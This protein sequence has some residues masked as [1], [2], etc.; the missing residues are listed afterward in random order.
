MRCGKVFGKVDG[1]DG[2]ILDFDKRKANLLSVFAECVCDDLKC[3]K[4]VIRVIKVCK[5]C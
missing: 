3:V 5:Y 4:N 2:V 1:M